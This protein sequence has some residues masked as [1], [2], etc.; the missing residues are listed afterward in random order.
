MRVLFIGDIVGSPG[1][2]AAKEM[3]SKLKKE[4]EID[5]CIANG[6]NAAGGSGITYVIAQELYNSGVDGITMGNHTW[7]K[8]EIL[9]FIESDNRLARPANYPQD[10]PGKGYA[11]LNGKNGK[12]AI[13]NLLGRIYMDNID[14]PFKAADRELEHIK[15]EVKAVVVDFHAEA[16]SEKT[17]LAWYLDGRVS[18]VLGT[19]THVQTADERIFPFGTAYITDVGM[20]GPCDGVIG[21]NKDI[22]IKKFLTGMPQRFEVAKGRIIFNAVLLDIEEK[23]GKTANIRRISMIMEPK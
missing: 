10:L 8:N 4:E 7:S 19:H 21:V 14:C 20:T 15:K 1:R 17:A 2:K 18:C 12:L 9:N 16:T 23:S 11:I 3:I 22:I 6:E 5:F 13:M